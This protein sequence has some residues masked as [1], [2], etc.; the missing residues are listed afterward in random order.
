MAKN[1]LPYY[2]CSLSQPRI[3]IC[4]AAIRRVQF[5]KVFNL[6]DFE[7]LLVSPDDKVNFLPEEYMHIGEDGELAAQ[8]TLNDAAGI[9]GEFCSAGC[10]RACKEECR[11]AD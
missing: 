9:V 4:C 8:R 6:G 11:K 7:I 1:N 3:S 5:S 2:P 10:H